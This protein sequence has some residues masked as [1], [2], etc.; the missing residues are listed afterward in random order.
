MN[1]CS[2]CPSQLH[3]DE[4][5]ARCSD[6]QGSGLES[7]GG[8]ASVCAKCSGEGVIK[9]SLDNATDDDDTQPYPLSRGD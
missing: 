2:I 4:Y 8:I 1:K 7:I 6:C 3:E 9:T 5:H